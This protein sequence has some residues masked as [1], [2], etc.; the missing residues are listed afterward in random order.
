MIEKNCCM[1]NDRF[2]FKRQ[3]EK[4]IPRVYIYIFK[5]YMYIQLLYIYIYIYIYIV[6]H[7]QTV[8]FY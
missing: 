2:F 4:S 1:N 6:I 3:K 5:V 7:K 8:S